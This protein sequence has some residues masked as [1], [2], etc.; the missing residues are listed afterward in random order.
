MEW[1]DANGQKVDSDMIRIDLS[2]EACHSR[3]EPYYMS[4]MSNDIANIQASITALE[5][6]VSWS[7]M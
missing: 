7:D 6:S 1:Y 4:N 2:N 5:E 3:I